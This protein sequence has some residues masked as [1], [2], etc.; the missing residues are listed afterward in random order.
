MLKNIKKYIPKRKYRERGQLEERKRKGFLE[1]KQDYKERAIDFQRKRDRITN[2]IE[3][4]RT[5]NPDE[6][7]HKM[8][9]EN[10]LNNNNYS[11]ENIDKFRKESKITHERYLNLVN[12]KA[13]TLKKKIDNIVSNSSFFNLDL[14]EDECK[15]N[16]NNND[17]NT[18]KKYKHKIFLNDIEEVNEF[19]ASKYFDTPFIES[20]SN[21]LKNKQLETDSLNVNRNVKFLDKNNKVIEDK[22]EHNDIIKAIHL[23][24]N[25]NNLRNISNKL[26]FN[27]NLIGPSKKR[28]I[29]NSLGKVNY[30]FFNER[31]K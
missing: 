20:I 13:S 30:K 10:N 24:E 18:N 16:N 31:K 1:K 25:Y 29:T 23:K 6:F 28:K 11:K 26:E 14:N 5:K 3:K 17:K 4:V 22:N 8:I 7:Y 12:Y 19:N 21:R 9:S 2:L 15:N 27:K